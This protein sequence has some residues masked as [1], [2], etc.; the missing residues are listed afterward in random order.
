MKLSRIAK[1]G[2]KTV[3]THKLRAIFMVLSV[4]IGIAALTVIISL[5]R[6]TEEKI[7][8]QVRKLFS[9]NTIMV[10]AGKGR[11]ESN[12]RSGSSSSTLKLGDFEDIKSKVVDVIYWDAV[13]VSP[14]RQVSYGSKSTIAIIS[15]QTPASETV[16]NIDVTN[17]RFFTEAEDRNLNRVALVAPNVARELFGNKNP[18]GEEIRVENIPFR[19]I[20]MIAKRG[21][22]PHGIDKDSEILVPLNTLL[23]R[24]VNFDYVMLGKLLVT[25]EKNINATAKEVSRILREKHDLSEEESDDFMIITPTMVNKMIKDSNKV[26]NTYLPLIAIIS[27]LVGSIVISNLM[28]LSVNERKKEIGLRK[29]VGAKTRDILLQFL[30]EASSI[31]IF[32]GILG[33]GIGLFVLVLIYPRMNI[34]FSISWSTIFICFVISTLI[35]IVSGYLPAKK[36]AELKPVEALN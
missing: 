10:V 35:G 32:S 1:S 11:M 13:Q 14:D 4:M 7:M 22:D 6:G 5:G 25:D 27:L 34:P 21:M 31:T 2:Y 18:I 20:G 26:F 23:R 33:I 30:L 28:L 9:S 29:A 15:G 24:V 36:A 17:G 12:Q 19:V 3:M 16:W 8:G